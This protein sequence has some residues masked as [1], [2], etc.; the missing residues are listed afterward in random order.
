MKFVN[1]AAWD[2]VARVALGVVVLY[3]GWAEVVTGG[4]GTAL[5]VIGFIPLVTGIMGWCPL[6]ALFRFRTNSETAGR[7]EA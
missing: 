2:R 7:V 6:Y 3:L 1:E 4:W 5:K